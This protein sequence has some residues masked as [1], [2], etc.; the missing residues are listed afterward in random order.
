[1]KEKIYCHWLPIAIGIMGIGIGCDIGVQVTG[2]ALFTVSE[3]YM[4]YLFAAIVSVGLLGF[5]LIALVSGLLQE[6][7]YGYKLSELLVFEGIRKRIN[8]RK[9]LMVSLAQVILG[10]LYLSLFFQVSCVNSMIYLLISAVFSAGCMAYSIF[11][12]MVNNQ[13]VYDILEEGYGSLLEMDLNRNKKYLHH[14]TTLSNALINAVES[15]NLEETEEICSLYAVLLKIVDSK[16]DVE[17]EQSSFLRMKLKQV[18]CSISTA[19]GYLKMIEEITKMFCDISNYDYWKTDLY[20]Q[21]ISNLKYYDDKQLEECDYRNQVLEI[22]V[23]KEYKDGFITDNDW[24]D[25]LYE[26]FLSLVKNKSCTD[27]IK[28]EMLNKFLAELLNFTRNSGEIALL[29]EEK[30]A[31]YILNYILNLNNMEEQKKIY[32]L[33]L[34]NIAVHNQY[35][36]SKD[37]FLL[38]SIVFQ[39]L[40]AYAYLEREVRTEG[41]RKNIRQLVDNSV[42]DS[43]ING[44]KIAFLL[45]ADIERVLRSFGYRIPKDFSI[46]NSFEASADFIQVKYK[47]WTEEYNIKFFFMMY[48][49]YYDHVGRY[50]VF[51]FLQWDKYTNETKDKI[52]K[53]FV[54]CFDKDSGMLDDTFLSECRQLGELYNYN[55][56]IKKEQQIKVYEFIQE[57]QRNLIDIK[58]SENEVDEEGRLDTKEI[59]KYLSEDIKRNGA[60]GWSPDRNIEF[61][62]KYNDVKAIMHYENISDIVHE[63]TVAHFI[64]KCGY[65]AINWFIKN[66]CKKITAIYNM[67]GIQQ[68]LKCIED[69]NFS[70][71][72]FSYALDM[73][74]DKYSETDAYRRLSEKENEIELRTMNFI[75]EHI[76]AKSS[77][78]YFKLLPSKARMRY[79]NESECLERVEKFER[80]KEYYYVDGVLLDRYRAIECIKRKYFAYEFDF[81]LYLDFKPEDVMWFG[82]PEH[83]E[84]Q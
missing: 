83:D 5:S 48:C 82:Y 6:K 53:L 19:F 8:L 34:R 77:N 54:K 66:K 13:A 16:N 84:G 60:Y 44:L 50:S 59:A 2:F 33:F 55:Y 14:V 69:N 21:P 49:K 22:C 1:M 47:I 32:A 36:D 15:G 76:Y 62:I 42:S 30:V 45:E 52:L 39:V 7:F 12:I 51:S 75:H 72:N 25:I 17:W 38:L 80:Y 56:E 67:E 18:C 58:M 20:L 28:Y 61:Y 57:Q 46:V 27:E 68:V 24:K 71:K 40:Y 10:I 64:K 43:M 65:D 29:M 26:Y 81:K 78:F 31:L 70:I 73:A 35:R 37:Y 3:S 9:Y 23:L 41:Y 74:L 11:D 63:R 79:L 4:D